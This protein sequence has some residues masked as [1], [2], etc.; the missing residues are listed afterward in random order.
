MQG[1][2]GFVLRERKQEDTLFVYLCKTGRKASL[3]E[4]RYVCLCVFAR[5]PKCR[6]NFISKAKEMYSL[7]DL[8]YS[9]ICLKLHTNKNK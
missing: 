2:E 1:L 8:G 3:S 6:M 4:A 7:T 9:A 5:V